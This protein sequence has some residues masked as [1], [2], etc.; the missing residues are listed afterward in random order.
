M[1][2]VSGFEASRYFG[3]SREAKVSGAKS[4]ASNPLLSGK[5]RK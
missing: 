2:G 4:V 3:Y 5:L 1:S